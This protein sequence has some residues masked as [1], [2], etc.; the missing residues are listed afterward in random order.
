MFEKASFNP[1]RKQAD[2]IG[3][4]DTGWADEGLHPET[5]W[6]GYATGLGYAW[7]PGSPSPQEA[8]GSFFSL[9]YGPDTENM[10][11]VYQ[12]MSL[13]ARFWLDSW[14]DI[15]TTTRKPIFGTWD[16]IYNPPKTFIHH[17]GYR[18]KPAASAYSL[19][20]LPDAGIRLERPERE[21]GPARI[22]I[23]SG[24]R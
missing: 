1:A 10:G 8:T 4:I 9:F 2:L 3:I 16:A 23:S 6:L 19:A 24:Q 12:L 22:G 18:S 11:R 17:L 5:Y 21:K 14:D 20:R 7:H 13:Q 15:P